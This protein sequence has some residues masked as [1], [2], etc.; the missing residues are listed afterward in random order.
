MLETWKDKYRLINGIQMVLRGQES[1]HN[2]LN[3]YC[4]H[5]TALTFS[6]VKLVSIGLKKK[7]IP[8]KKNHLD[9]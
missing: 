2:G 8:E 6:R 1:F 4:F 3:D 7:I 9:N 5:F